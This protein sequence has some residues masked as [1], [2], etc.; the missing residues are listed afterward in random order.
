MYIITSQPFGFQVQNKLP[1]N[2][3]PV[4]LVHHL[5]PAN[6]EEPHGPTI[7]KISNPKIRI[8]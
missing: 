4:Q 3:I 6:D 7:R 2:P 8:A 1:G 5:T